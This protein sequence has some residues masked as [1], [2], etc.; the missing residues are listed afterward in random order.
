MKNRITRLILIAFTLLFG[1]CVVLVFGSDRLYSMSLAAQTGKIS[2]EK[3]IALLDAAIRLDP[4]NTGL[5]FEKCKLMDK[6]AYN[7]QLKPGD[8]LYER[9]LQVIA[10][11]IDL[12][13]SSANYHFYYAITTMEVH[14]R[15]THIAAAYMLSELLKASE[16]R[17]ASRT[18]REKCDKYEKK[19][20]AGK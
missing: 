10:R 16:L 11:C 3:G 4:G 18:Y 6:V 15:L 20:G 5:Y 13:P 14:P 7:G 2:P 17:P 12:S 1:S 19:Y 8:L 9:Q